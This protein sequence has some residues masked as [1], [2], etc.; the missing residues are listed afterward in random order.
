[1][2]EYLG[3]SPTA[4]AGKG[5]NREAYYEMLKSTAKARDHS[6]ITG[7]AP[8]N[9]TLRIHKSFMTSTSP[10][11]QNI[12]GTLIGD[13]LLFPDALDYRYH[14]KGGRFAW[15]V[16]PSTRPIVAGRDGR[17]PVG[18]KQTDIP[19]A[20]P[21]GIPAENVEADYT[22]GAY[23]AIPFHVDG[24]PNVDN[25]RMTVHIEWGNPNT[26]WDL[27][28]VNSAGEVVTQ[29]ASFGDTTEDAVLVDPPPGDYVA[30]VVN[31]DQIDGAPALDDWS[32][33]QVLFRSPT[34][35]FYGAKEA[36][37]L[38]CEDPQGRVRATRNVVVDRG[39]KV[40]VGK[41][42]AAGS[43]AAAKAAG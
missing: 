31:F 5:G 41:V 28:V 2:D 26:D 17:D 39:D 22:T 42:C 14:S 27:Y 32:N 4:G 1:V 38:S 25:G 34:P 24:P 16:N 15:N 20:N 6:L 36:W 23:E 21:A 43:L 35:R 18:P 7:K 30:H 11:W 29:S 33:G 19:L 3:L 37:Q 13:P 8:R 9:W 12:Y 10:V 40:S